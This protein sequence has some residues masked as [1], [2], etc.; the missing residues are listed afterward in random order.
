M[1]KIFAIAMAILL[2]AAII[3]PLP[4]YA[5]EISTTEESIVEWI[6]EPAGTE[7]STEPETLPGGE[8]A[9]E[10]ET[11]PPVEVDE[12]IYSILQQATPEQVKLIEGIVLGGVGALDKLGIN[13]FDRI[14]VFVE[15]N[16]A[17]VMVAALVIALVAFFVVTL[18]QKR[19]LH[20]D[21]K[22]FYKS[23][24]EE[25]KSAQ[26]ACKACTESAEKAAKSAEEAVFKVSEE[27]SLMM[28]EL[29][30]NERVNRALCEEIKFLMQCSDLS[31]SKREE[32]EAIF[33]R[34]MEAMDDGTNEA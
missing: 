7:P 16:M 4:V 18:I 34:G 14:R 13:G 20:S 1:K 10:S 22:D 6:T 27:R 32:A 11:A 24:K 9:G 2:L 12:W 5:E 21:S 25:V 26:K 30:R 19:Q 17:T 28:A 15:Y 23:G 31:Q 29:R 33:L 8:T 3:I